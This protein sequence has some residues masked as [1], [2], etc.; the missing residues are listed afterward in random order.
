VFNGP[1]LSGP[2]RRDA[3]GPGGPIFGPS[4]HVLV[5]QT[6]GCIFDQVL[7]DSSSE[8]SCQCLPQ[9]NLAMPPANFCLPFCRRQAF[10]VFACQAS[11]TRRIA[12][13]SWPFASFSRQRV[14]RGLCLV[15]TRSSV[16]VSLA[17]RSYP[18]R[19]RAVPSPSPTHGPGGARIECS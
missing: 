15:F 1:G 17:A 16:K 2:R 6:L 12:C 10:Q 19:P 9:C 4:V 8:S 5:R 18:G 13:D 14:C 11:A 7:Q 3:G